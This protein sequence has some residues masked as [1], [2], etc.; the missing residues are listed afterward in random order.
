[1]LYIQSSCYATAAVL[2]AAHCSASQMA[3]LYSTQLAR[4]LPSQLQQ[5]SLFIQFGR[6][7]AR[8]NVSEMARR[9]S[10]STMIGYSVSALRSSL[11]G[12]GTCK[13]SRVMAQHGAL[14]H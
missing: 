4:Q 1:M 3:A 9:T 14:P 2:A 11:L 6:A 7:A 8:H 12:S 10:Y 13:R 5:C